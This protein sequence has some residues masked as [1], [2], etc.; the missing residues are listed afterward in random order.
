MEAGWNSRIFVWHN[1]NWIPSGVRD[2]KLL[3]KNTLLVY[4][5]IMWISVCYSD[6]KASFFFYYLFYPSVGANR[7]ILGIS[8]C[9]YIDEKDINSTEEE[10]KQSWDLT[11]VCK[12]YP[13]KKHG[14]GALPCGLNWFSSHLLTLDLF[15]IQPHFY[16]YFPQFTWW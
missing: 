10:N 16:V 6:W 12:H 15:L 11:R 3:N 9:I 1:A 2:V 5:S 13:S 8:E 14:G 7:L 4:N